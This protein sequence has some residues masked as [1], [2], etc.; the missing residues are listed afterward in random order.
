M[1]RGRAGD[2]GGG[3]RRPAAAEEALGRSLATRPRRD[4]RVDVRSRGR[5]G[6]TIERPG[7]TRSGRR[8]S[9]FRRWRSWPTHRVRCRVVLR[10]VGVR[11]ADRDHVGI[12]RRVGR[13]CRAR[14][15]PVVAR[16]G[17]DD[18]ALA[19]R[20]L[21]G[22]GER[23]ELRSSGSE[24]VPNERLS[25]RMFRPLSLR[26]CTTQSIAAIT[27]ETSVAPS[28]VGDLD[29]DDARHPA[30]CRGSASASPAY[31]AGLAP[32]SRGRR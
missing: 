21:G 31:F 14:S 7:A 1:Q 9:C 22:E 15:K 23:V 2:H 6:S 32:P 13:G 10:A 29:V 16:G 27:W 5:A 18:D 30:P 3:L 8:A 12:D 20:H 4:S 24:S 28:A 11:R 25:T 26:C 17:Y 19:P